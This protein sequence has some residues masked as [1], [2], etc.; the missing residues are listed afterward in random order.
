MITRR[1]FVAKAAVGFA[2]LVGLAASQR[3]NESLASAQQVP[4]TVLPIKPTP[5]RPTEAH[6]VEAKIRPVRPEPW[7]V[8]TFRYTAKDHTVIP[9]KTPL[10]DRQLRELGI[11]PIDF[12]LPHLIVVPVPM[13]IYR[14]DTIEFKLDGSSL[15]YLKT[16]DDAPYVMVFE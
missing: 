12:P 1:G 13:R 2:G 4:D 10:S 5:A 16:P 6:R 9:A 11:V 7:T 3:I 14:G 8:R 15:N